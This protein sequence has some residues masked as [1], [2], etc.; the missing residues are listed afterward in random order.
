[1]SHI[2]I[3]IIIPIYNV[4]KYLKNCLDSCFDQDIPS[5]EYEVIAVNDGSP[6]QCGIILSEYEKK[7]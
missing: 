1:M 4:E 7:I 6:D 3:S 2:K 5:S